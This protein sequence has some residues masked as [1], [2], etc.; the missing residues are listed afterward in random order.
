MSGFKGRLLAFLLLS[1]LL[2]TSCSISDLLDDKGLFPDLKEPADNADGEGNPQLDGS[3]YLY[4]EIY[5]EI[6]LEVLNTSSGDESAAADKDDKSD[7]NESVSD[8]NDGKNGINTGRGTTGKEA[9]PGQITATMEIKLYFADRAAVSEGKP[10]PYGFVAPAVRRVPATSGILKYTLNEL[11]KGPLPQEEGL[12]PVLPS[13]V[14]VNGIVIKDRVAVI[15][16]SKALLTDHPG[17]TMG[18]TITQQALVFTA[19]QFDSVDGVMVTVE[20]SPWDDGHF[21]WE[22]PIYEEELIKS[23]K[24]N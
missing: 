24:S 11:I 13:T 2:L 15:D 10:G 17:G 9:E 12:D 22:Y 21:I 18:A 1:L 7:E 19:S 20:G 4:D 8:N 14:K 3:D 23:M 6:T 16:F 5:D